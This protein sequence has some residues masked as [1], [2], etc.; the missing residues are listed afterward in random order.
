MVLVAPI[1]QGGN[2]SRYNGFTVTLSGTGSKTKGVILMNQVKMVD[3]E[4]RNGKFI[5]SAN[6]IVVEDALAK[7]MAIIE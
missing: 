5:E 7:L 2:Y 4:S 1:T 3:L 6:P